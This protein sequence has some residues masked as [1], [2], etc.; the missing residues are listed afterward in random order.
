MRTVRI[1]IGN[2]IRRLGKWICGPYWVCSNCGTLKD[3]E[4]EILCWSCGVGEMT[5]QGQSPQPTERTT[6]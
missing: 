6:L 4:A 2:A 5:Y 1:K 3:K